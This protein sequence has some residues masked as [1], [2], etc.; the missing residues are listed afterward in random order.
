MHKDEG[1]PRPAQIA[2]RREAIAEWLHR[3]GKKGLTAPQIHARLRNELGV[4]M[5][6]KTVQRDLNYLKGWGRI[7]PTD[8]PDN[9]A[10]L[11]RVVRGAAAPTPAAATDTKLSGPDLRSARVALGIVT[12]YEQASHL[13][14]QAAL[15]DLREQYEIS[16][17]L[18]TRLMPQEGRWLG[19]LVTGTQHIQLLQAAIDP[20]V[21]AQVQL[22]L[23]GGYQ[24]AV[25]YF[26]SNQQQEKDYQLH[27]LG[28][29]YQDSSIYLVCHSG[30][31]DRIRCLPLHRFRQVRP[32]ESRLAE[33]PRD[34]ELRNHVQR[35]LI[36]PE[37]IVLK[38]R[39]NDR[40]RQRLDERETPLAHEQVFTPLGN[41]WHL[42]ECSIA[43]SQGLLWWILSHGATVEVLEPPSLR[44]QVRETVRTLA[45]F[46][47][48]D[49]AGSTELPEL[50]HDAS[51]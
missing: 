42:L 11:W 36:E 2:Q 35:I 40:L 12:L 6:I 47:L 21:L 13:L 25:R 51:H 41:G 45:G 37:P 46:Y 1:V 18:L 29:S 31:P 15:D 43:Y 9:A 8:E 10:P 27:P 24:L 23:L 34:F 39:I 14:H 48:D 3:A 38:L 44:A 50:V 22:A 5:T 4:D 33:V 28:L 19:K 17:A 30:D 26:A 7:Q 49:A 16:K 32:L 20:Q